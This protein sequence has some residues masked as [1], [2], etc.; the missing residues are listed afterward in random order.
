M[1]HRV[2]TAEFI[3]ESN[4]FKKGLTELHNFEVDV[5]LEGDAALDRL[6]DTNTGLAGFQDVATEAGWDMMHVISAYAVPGSKVSKHAFD[7]VSDKI[8]AAAQKHKDS[9]DGILLALHGAMVTEFCEDGEGEL[10]QR[11][12]DIVGPAMPISTTLDLHCN[13]T[14]QMVELADIIVSYKTYPH[15]DLRERGR[16]AGHI[17]NATMAGKISPKTRRAHCPMLDDPNGGRTDVGPIVPLYARALEH[18]AEPGIHCVSINAGFSDADIQHMGPT[19]LVTYDAKTDGAEDRAQEISQQIATEIWQARNSIANDFL[20]VEAA[21][22][23]AKSFDTA[24]GPLVIADYADNPGSG[25]YGDATNLLAAMLDAGLENAT[26]APMIDPEAAEMLCKHS[27]GDTVTLSLGGKNDPAFGGGPLE[28]TGEIRHISDGQLIGD[29]PMM[30]GL[31]RSFGP[32]AVLRVEGV[33]ILVVTERDQMLDLQQFK[34]FGIQPEEKS[35]VALK[36]MQHFR[37]AFE[38]IAG[39]VIVCDSGA[40]STPQ[41]SRRP[42]VNVRRPIWPLDTEAQ[43]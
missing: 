23:V 30:G 40:L 34:T 26:F 12:R 36:S 43:M 35:V 6:C 1:T 11:L 17:L 15:I 24:Q 31:H 16:Q 21:C 8:C 7:Y 29:G 32:T 37:A 14:P 13:V 27:I 9:L 19:V 28:L 42:Y 39:K 25:A 38:P 33:D 5:L 20:S 22:A 4:T 41:M 2:L 3:H 18:E 10:L